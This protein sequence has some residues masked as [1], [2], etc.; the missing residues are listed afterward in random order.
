MFRVIYRWEVEPE[1]FD[2]FKSVWQRTTKQIHKTVSGALGSFMLK[3][4]ENSSEILTIAKWDSYE[5]WKAFWGNKNP[6]EMKEMRVLGKRISVETYSEV[7]D[8]TY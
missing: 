3:N 1:N 7:E 8:H 4:H 2:E 6:E 5:S